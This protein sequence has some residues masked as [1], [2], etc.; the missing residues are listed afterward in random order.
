MDLES[1]AFLVI[2]EQ[3]APER[4]AATHAE[5]AAP[6]VDLSVRPPYGPLPPRRAARHPCR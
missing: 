2:V 5:E 6:S 3:R 1:D 4:R